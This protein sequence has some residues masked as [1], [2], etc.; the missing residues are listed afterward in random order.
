MSSCASL[1][2]IRGSLDEVSS[3]VDI[4]WVQPRVLE[5]SQLDTLANQFKAWTAGVG[6][7]EQNVDQLR[8]EARQLVAAS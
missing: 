5:G 4:T 1:S 3:T 6:R 2:L 8:G 7:T